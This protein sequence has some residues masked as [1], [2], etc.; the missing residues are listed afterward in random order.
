MKRIIFF[1][2]LFPLY[3]SAQTCQY[4]AYEGF[5]YAQNTPLHNQFGGV[6]WAERWEVQN[7][8]I[9]IPGFMGANSSPMIWS[10]LLGFGNYIVGGNSYLTIGRRLNLENTG[11]F[12]AYLNGN[13]RIGLAG[14]TLYM[15]VLVRKEY[16]I[17]KLQ[18]LCYKEGIMFLG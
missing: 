11:A 7:N 10:N 8:N 1:I 16:N 12:A 4:L 2:L 18:Q 15:S 5:N 9:S 6:G 3:L 17:T 14:T 13:G